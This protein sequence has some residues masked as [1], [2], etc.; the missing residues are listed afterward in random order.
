MTPYYVYCFYLL[1]HSFLKAVKLGRKNN[2]I[3]Q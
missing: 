2:V 3:R 1:N